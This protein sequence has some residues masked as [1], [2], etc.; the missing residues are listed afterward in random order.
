MSKL[1]FYMLFNCLYSIITVVIILYHK[2]YSVSKLFIY[3]RSSVIL[4]FNPIHFYVRNNV[5]FHNYA[6]IRLYSYLL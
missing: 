1:F 4:L 5:F 2:I 6:I 3:V